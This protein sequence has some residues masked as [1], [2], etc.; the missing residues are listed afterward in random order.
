MRHAC[1][2]AETLR[3]SGCLIEEIRRASLI[4]DVGKHALPAALLS[5][6][7]SLTPADWHLIRG[8]P[9]LG[10]QL[11]AQL[12]YDAAVR[13]LVR[14]HHEHWDGSGYPQR[15]EGVDIPLGARIIA[16]ADVFD[17]LTS[18][19]PYRV[20]LP[21]ATA[22]AVMRAESGTVLDPDLFQLFEHMIERTLKA[23]SC[24]QTEHKRANRFAR[25]TPVH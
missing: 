8:H 2:L 12:G 1:R 14:H 4:H 21:A 9:E 7:T 5:K 13:A 22:L 18:T 15:L 24:T 16:I 20:A 23:D 17:A 3:L 19:R 6:K 10:S 25:Y 11:A